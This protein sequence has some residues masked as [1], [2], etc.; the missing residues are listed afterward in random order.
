[1]QFFI[2]VKRLTKRFV[3]QNTTLESDRLLCALSDPLDGYNGLQASGR[4]LADSDRLSFIYIIDSNEGYLYIEFPSDVWPNL[5]KG[6]DEKRDV[7]VVVGRETFLELTNLRSGMIYLIDNI[8][9][10]PN[11]GENMVTEV[12]KHF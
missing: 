2:E 10:N 6:L 3:V 12:A 7:F 9:E 8:A 1:M 11:Y 4:M 5:K